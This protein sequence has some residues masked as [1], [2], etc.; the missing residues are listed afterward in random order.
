M[1]FGIQYNVFHARSI[2]FLSMVSCLSVSGRYT[3]NV[4]RECSPDTLVK[5]FGM[6]EKKMLL[7]FIAICLHIAFKYIC[8]FPFVRNV[9]CFNFINVLFNCSVV[10][11]STGEGKKTFSYMELAMM[12]LVHV[13][14][15]ICMRNEEPEN[16]HA[17]NNIQYYPLKIVN[18]KLHFNLWSW[19]WFYGV[20]GKFMFRFRYFFYFHLI[21][22]L[23]L[24]FK[25][26][27]RLFRNNNTLN[28]WWI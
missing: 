15:Q 28:K 27:H 14:I 13:Y 19:R 20:Q 7:R 2:S 21:Q 6:N 1:G 11:I 25:T 26:T 4:Y 17:F 22:N 3:W 24:V 12:G 18:R 5:V 9:Y 23:S 8:F 16:K 10:F